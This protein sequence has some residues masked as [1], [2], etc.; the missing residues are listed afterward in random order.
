MKQFILPSLIGL[1]GIVFVVFGV[2]TNKA[3]ERR[4]Q[5]EIISSVTDDRGLTS[6]IYVK[7]SD[8]LALDYLTRNEF[9]KLF[10][11]CMHYYFFASEVLTIKYLL[12]TD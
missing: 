10:S 1:A 11:I 4:Q 12:S 6:V 3:P 9:N 7:G 8:T 5:P 2:V